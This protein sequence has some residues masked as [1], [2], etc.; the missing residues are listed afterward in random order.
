MYTAESGP[1]NGQLRDYLGIM[2]KRRFT[3][4]TALVVLASLVSIA[5]FLSKPV[6]KGT[7]QILI[8]KENPNVL[9]FQEVLALEAADTSYY[10][11]QY[12][13]LQSRTLA[14]KVI[15]E[16]GLAQ[17]AEFQPRRGIRVFGIKL[18][19]GKAGASGDLAR[20]TD[21]VDVFLSKLEVEPIRNSRLVEVSFLSWD[22]ELAARV[23]NVVAQ[24]YVEQDL[25]ARLAVTRQAVG[26]LNEQVTELK[27]KVQESEKALQDY[28]EKEG[29]IGFD[30][31]QNIVIQ[32]LSD[33]NRAVTE[34]QTQRIGVET[35]YRQLKA[36]TRNP[37]MIESLPLVI[38][39]RLVQ[40]LKV[41][42]V[43]LQAE[44]SKLSAKYGPKHPEMIRIN[45]QL[46]LMREKIR[47]EVSNVVASIETEYR[48][49]L[50]K[51]RSLKAALDS[52]KLEAQR[53][54]E[55]AI[56]YSVLAREAESNQQLYDALLR[57]MKETGVA[58]GLR[59]SNIRIVDKAE[60]PLKPFRPRKGWNI[61]LSLLGGLVLGIG[62]AFFFEY[63]DDTVKTPDDL[64]RYAA[65]PFLGPVPV[66]SMEEGGGKVGAGLFALPRS[67]AAEAYRS[68]RTSLLFSSSGSP[69]ASILVTSPLPL[70]GKTTTA[71]NLAHAL[72]QS[73]K[74]VIL[75]DCDMRKPGLHRE[76]GLE[77]ERGLSNFIVGTSRLEEVIQNTD[78]PNFQVIPCGP[79]PPNPS[80]L[81]GSDKLIELLRELSAAYDHVILD[82]PPVTVVTDPVV[83]SK[84]VD[85]VVLVI[86]ASVTSKEALKS[87]KKQLADVGS[88]I[89]GG[90]LN[91]LDERKGK[92]YYHGYYYH[93]GDEHRKGG[94][95]SDRAGW[96]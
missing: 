94:G 90:V 74:K 8:E 25:E 40:D 27:R 73:D 52:Q 68:L 23:A 6:Y 67:A 39:N 34:A 89:L 57:R 20:Q 4:L 85:G 3:I 30:E 80:E 45:S 2:S 93:Y 24:K 9:S 33:L 44:Y 77:N 42:Y 10:Q 7:V 54:N 46:K 11:T 18:A 13:I 66:I 29:L 55:K 83:L 38:Q 65:I 84:A 69:P 28:K 37:A 50:Q 14:R 47:A 17:L 81:L 71:V 53:L 82:S 49:A 79:I 60:V 26:W 95:E 59:T 16:L 72:A 48:V 88:K 51:E 76:L 15:N 32:K 21:I 62:L 58:T 86:K 78:Q 63:L 12:R 43:G 91:Q 22:A 31:R 70:E 56:R 96:V 35:V 64:S 87:A 1:G 61:A 41:T 36:V 75:V 19:A 92:Y 5:T